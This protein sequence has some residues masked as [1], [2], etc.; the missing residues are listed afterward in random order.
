MEVIRE[1]LKEAIAG[2]AATNGKYKIRIY[3]EDN[4]AHDYIESDTIKSII[5][6]YGDRYVDSYDY[7]NGEYIFIV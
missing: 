1:T 4:L 7:S 5:E 2:I 3:Y 6:K